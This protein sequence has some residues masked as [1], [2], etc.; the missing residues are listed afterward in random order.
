MEDMLTRRMALLG[1]GAG[2]AAPAIGQS[3]GGV[4]FADYPFQLGV[5]AGDPN[6]SGFVIWT[7]I[8]PRPGEPDRGLGNRPVPVR[9]E[10][11]DTPGFQK[12]V[13]AGEVIARPELG[14]SVHV[15]L[16]ALAPDRVYHYRFVAGG[17][18]SV[19]GRART[20]PVPGADARAVK[21]GVAGCQEYQSGLY[22]AYRHLARE[23]CHAIF[24]Y[25]DYI[26]ESGPRAA[27]FSSGLGEMVPTVRQH[28]GPE[29]Y[30]L[31]DY[32]RRY[33]QTRLDLD[34]QEAHRSA[35][36]LASYDD[37]EVDNNWAG[38]I[39]QDGT[40][41]E[42]FLLRR[43]AAMQAWYEFMPVRRDAFPKA[44]MSGPWRQYRWGRLLD[45]RMLNTRAFRTD[46]PC[47]DRFGSLCEGVRDPRAEMI[48][49]VQED[50]LAT[51]LGQAR[52]S[53][54]LQQVMMMNLERAREPEPRGVNVDSWAGYLVPRDR[55]LARLSGVSNLVVLTGDEHQHWAGEVRRSDARPDS[56]AQAVEFVTTSISSG[57]DGPGVRPEHAA[58]LS[59]N[60]GLS[61]IRDERGYSVMTVAPDS[62]TAE[63]KVVDTVR[64][65]GGRLSTAA[66][67]RVPAGA[68][69]LERA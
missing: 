53:A 2:L 36:W 67:F 1:L 37:H 6:A 19:A 11:S 43:A 7:R 5:A 49:R 64:A 42:Y 30:S 8:A 12:L 20:L 25:G 44:G 22:T 10:V 41:P 13:A 32:R 48:G 40:D 63:L 38:A 17:E 26:Y 60:P 46:Q 35:A 4:P 3:T 52:W 54:L 51:G 50:W 47:G 31:D 21:L 23:D 66:T 33:T 65:A 24:H 29:T 45:A 55:L 39:D 18:R 58:I 27:M 16:D 68:S 69:R 34:L 15:T 61:Y 62:W 9:Y 28:N 59:R 14:H 57:S 56:A